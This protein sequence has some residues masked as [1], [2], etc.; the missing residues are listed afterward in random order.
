MARGYIRF[1]QISMRGSRAGATGILSA[2][3][4]SWIGLRKGAAGRCHAHTTPH[5]ASPA[6]DLGVSELMI[7]ALVGHSARGVTQRYIHI[8]EALRMTADRVAAE[9]ADLAGRPGGPGASASRP[10]GQ[11]KASPLKWPVEDAP[12]ACGP[13]GTDAPTGEHIGWIV[14]R[15]R[16]CRCR[17]RS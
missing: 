14:R 15:D 7:A 8:D 9:L 12:T 1:L 5:F 6:G 2:W 10:R 13:C 4:E 17:Q 3:F 11:F 16:C